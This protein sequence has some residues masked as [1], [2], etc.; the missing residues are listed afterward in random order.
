MTEYVAIVVAVGVVGIILGYL[1][2]RLDAVYTMLRDNQAG[3][4]REQRQPTSFFTKERRREQAAV[5]EKI[6]Q[7][8][9]DSSKFVT[10]IRTD[11]IKKL[12]DTILGKT[13]TQ[14]DTINQSV[15]KLAQLK[16]RE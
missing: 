9:I 15:S 3:L 8:S 2:A 4:T 11:N 10:D 14:Q 13:T 12:T 5:E 6:G 1:L 7:I 16:G